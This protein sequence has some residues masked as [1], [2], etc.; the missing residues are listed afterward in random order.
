MKC[1]VH[2]NQVGAL[3]INSIF[4]KL[5]QPGVYRFFSFFKTHRFFVLPTVEQHAWV[6]NQEIL[7]NDNIAFRLSFSYQYLIEEPEKFL[8]KSPL[9]Q[10]DFV[11]LNLFENN[12]SN[13]LKILIRRRISETNISQLNEKRETLFDGLQK[14]ANQ[15]FADYGVRVTSLAPLD[16]SFPKNIQEIFAKLLEARV[17]SQTDLE[18]ARTQVAAARALK[19]AAEISKGDKE[20]KHLQFME[21][22]TRI[23]SKGNHTFVLGSD[24]IRAE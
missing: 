3:Y 2:P 10:K 24:A 21:L 14:I 6:G 5:Y 11:V 17:R 22:L 13:A 12:L 8:Q 20:I 1:T 9:H 18:N 7:T 16:F 19:N 15:E 4:Q 23:A